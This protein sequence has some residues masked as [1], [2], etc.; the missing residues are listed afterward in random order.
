[1]KIILQDVGGVQI[2]GEDAPHWSH[3]GTRLIGT[4]LAVFDSAVKTPSINNDGTRD[5]F[6]L[7]CRRGQEAYQI[8]LVETSQAI[9]FKDGRVPLH[10]S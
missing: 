7:P 4:A 10:A 2:F 8:Y 1:V 3:K 5:Y 9:V 6:E